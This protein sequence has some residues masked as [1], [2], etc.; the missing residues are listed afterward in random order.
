MTEYRGHPVLTTG[1]GQC[2][3]CG[4]PVTRVLTVEYGQR[5]WH[6]VDKQGDRFIPHQCPQ[7]KGYL[8]PAA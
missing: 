2:A 1:P 7:S 8:R 3:A 4:E 6:V 5:V